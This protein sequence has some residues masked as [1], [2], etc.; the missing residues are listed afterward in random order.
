MNFNGITRAGLFIVVYCIKNLIYII[1]DIF[2]TYI[3]LS[4]SDDFDIIYFEITLC[5]HFKLNICNNTQGRPIYCPS[6]YSY[7][8]NILFLRAKLL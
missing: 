5:C 1:S 3:R 2:D 6:S 8:Q 4:D 7:R